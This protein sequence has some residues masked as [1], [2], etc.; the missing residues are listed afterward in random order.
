M[1]DYEKYV[2]EV[3]NIFSILEKLKNSWTNNDSLSSIEDISEYKNPVI[4]IASFLQGQ[5]KKDIE[6]D[7]ELL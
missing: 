6:E 1:N 4:Q 5:M 2:T 7:E 3:N